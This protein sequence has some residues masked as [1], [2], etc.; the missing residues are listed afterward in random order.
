[1]DE[2]DEPFRQLSQ[3]EFDAL[4]ANIL[5][6]RKPHEGQAPE[7]KRA[8]EP[9]PGAAGESSH[10]VEAAELGHKIWQW[11]KRGLS[12]YEV[13]RRLSIP[14][15]EVDELLAQFEKQFCPDIGAWMAHHAMLDNG[16][17]EDLIRTWHPVATGGPVEIQKVDKHGTVSTEIDAETP[18]KASAVVLGAIK[19]QIQLLVA[20]RP[21]T[22]NGKD[23]SATTTLVWLQTVLPNLQKVV[24]QVDSVEVPRER[25]VLECDSEISDI[26]STNGSNGSPR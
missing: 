7:E 24:Q 18:L 21:E 6:S 17:L 3:E 8:T 16:R 26:K 14:V 2:M 5:A 11:R 1:M 19:T 23:S 15:T 9:A 10:S 22:M 25:L 13:S 12:R 4:R 20:C